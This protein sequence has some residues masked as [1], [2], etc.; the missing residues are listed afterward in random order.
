MILKKEFDR[1]P[2]YN[3]TFLTTKIKS[4]SEG[5]TNFHDKAGSDYTCLAVINVDSAIKKDEH[6]Y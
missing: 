1:E 5:T 6:Y 4:F 3:K 2:V